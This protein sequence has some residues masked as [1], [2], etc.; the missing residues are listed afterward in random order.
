[1]AVSLIKRIRYDEFLLESLPLQGVT[2]FS[3]RHKEACANKEEQRAAN[4]KV[5]SQ[6]YNLE[7]EKTKEKLGKLEILKVL[8]ED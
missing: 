8:E 5:Y 1:M 6:A 3:D 2:E 7:R 4:Q